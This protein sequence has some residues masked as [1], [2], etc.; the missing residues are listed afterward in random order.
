M[1][2]REEHEFM[3]AARPVDWILDLRAMNMAFLV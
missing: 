3:V 2:P 1:D